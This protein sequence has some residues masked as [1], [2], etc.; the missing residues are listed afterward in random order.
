MGQV[1]FVFDRA[2]LQHDTGEGHPERAERLRYL[3]ESLEKT[4]LLTDL[5]HIA[6]TPASVEAV[7]WVHPRSHIEHVQNACKKGLFLLDSDT[8]VSKA[9]FDIAL[10]AAGGL[11]NACDSVMK[12]ECQHAFCAVRPPG[13]H[14][15]P[16]RAMGFCLFNNVAIAARY[17][18]KK[19][20]VEKVCI[21]DWD[22]HHGNGTQ[23]VFYDDPT[24]FYISTHQHPLYPGTG[25]V[26]ETGMG[27]GEGASLNFPMPPGQ[28]DREYLKI[29]EGEIASAVRNFG[30]DFLLI[31]AGFD[32]HRDDPL[33]N[34]ELSANGFYELTRI[35]CALADECC[36]GR[37]VSVLEGGYNL[38][39]LAQ[40]VEQHLKMMLN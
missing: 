34:M 21:I 29:F 24:V 9:S 15:E 12:G 19:H 31:S 11:I 1:G 10:L 26:E 6:V 39:A 32:A 33:A 2:F 27:E 36:E 14:A 13:H 37:L 35:V 3:I 23:A 25:R 17:L 40:S 38:Q 18:Q 20:A 30:P 28:G 7:E 5:N 8:V 16:T 22:V 4:G